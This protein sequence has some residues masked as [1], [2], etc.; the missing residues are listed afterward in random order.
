MFPIKLTE[1]VYV[2]PNAVVL[3]ELTPN[4]D[5]GEV[6]LTVVFENPDLSHLYLRGPE[7]VEAFANWQTAHQAQERAE[8]QSN[9]RNVE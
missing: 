9:G 1:H 6:F 2:N 8:T 4:N 3:V 5:G 7:A